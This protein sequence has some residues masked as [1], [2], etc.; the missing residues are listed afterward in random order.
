MFVA[1][2]KELRVLVIAVLASV[3]VA[4][5]AMGQGHNENEVVIPSFV[6]KRILPNL[7]PV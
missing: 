5:S 1:I 4:Y 6:T 7:E 3:S 2:E